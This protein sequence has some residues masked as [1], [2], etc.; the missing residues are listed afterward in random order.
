MIE[1]ELLRKHGFKIQAHCRYPYWIVEAQGQTWVIG[2]EDKELVSST[3]WLRDTLV[4][5]R[6][7]YSEVLNNP[8]YK[9]ASL[10]VRQQCWSLIA[11]ADPGYEIAA[12]LK[13]LKFIDP[14]GFRGSANQRKP[15]RRK[16]TDRQLRVAELT[17]KGMSD[18]EI[19]AELQIVPSAVSAHRNDIYKKLLIRSRKE[20]INWWQTKNQAA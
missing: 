18:R 2:K 4:S 19:A 11:S 9:R 17:A 13:Y 12:G 14:E 15:R 3:P 8:A 7:Y 1:L 16:L 20:L 6:E 10:E 5:I